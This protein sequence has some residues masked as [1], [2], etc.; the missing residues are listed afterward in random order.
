MLSYLIPV[1]NDIFESWR[2]SEIASSFLICK[3]TVLSCHKTDC[4]M[5]TLL[6]F[7]FFEYRF[8]SLITH[9]GSSV[10]GILSISKTPSFFCGLSF[11]SSANR[12]VRSCCASP[13]SATSSN[14]LFF[15]ASLLRAVYGV[16]SLNRGWIFLPKREGS[17]KSQRI[18]LSVCGCEWWSKGPS[19]AI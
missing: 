8:R 9:S 13:R 19:Q 14:V 3:Y 6:D 11:R 10:R 15:A 2:I 16:P 7:E 5:T 1:L 18:D 4:H 12:G 17:Q